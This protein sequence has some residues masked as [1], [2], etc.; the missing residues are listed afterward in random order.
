MAAGF[1]AGRRERPLRR[2]DR[3][4]VPMAL[5]DERLRNQVRQTVGL[6]HPR[7]SRCGILL[8][9]LLQHDLRRIRQRRAA[10][11]LR[12]FGL[13]GRH[14]RPASLFQGFPQ[15]LDHGMVRAH[16]HALRG[17]HPLQRTQRIFLLER[18][19]R[20]LQLHCGRL[21][22]LHQRG[23]RQH[24]GVLPHRADDAGADPRDAGR[25]MVS[26]PPRS[27]P[28]RPAERLALES[29]RRTGVHRRRAP[30]RLA[31]EL[32]H[33]VSGQ[34]ERLCKRAAG[35]RTLQILRRIRQERT[36]LQAILHHRT[37]RAG[38]S[39]RPWDL[40]QHGRQPA[41]RTLR[42]TRNP[43]Q[44]RADY[45]REHE[46]FVHGAFRQHEPSDAR[47]RLALQ[48]GTR[49]RPR[50]RDRQPHGARTGSRN[51]LAAALPRPEH[52]QAAEQC[53][54]A[55]HGCAAARKGL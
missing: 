49:L 30:R 37:R 5:L 8:R 17:R 4:R 25:D 51:P 11:R 14:V 52:H 36:Q 19:R 35:Q 1:P 27:G 24:H 43:P 29:G 55:L 28:R 31:A 7:N 13:L 26:L 42:R 18:I 41:R 47:T 12:R 6:H 32:Q 38:R 34:P 9:D 44:Y 10:N 3:I 2:D 23:G 16:H 15:L 39:L 46:C 20:T 40:R 33:P 54:H 21:P 50:I 22:R 53:R 45:D 48:A